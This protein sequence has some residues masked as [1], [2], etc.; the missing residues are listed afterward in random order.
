MTIDEPSHFNIKF[1]TAVKCSRILRHPNKN[2]VEELP[3][4]VANITLKIMENSQT[5]VSNGEEKLQ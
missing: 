3:A 5:E 2:E 4:A 1:E